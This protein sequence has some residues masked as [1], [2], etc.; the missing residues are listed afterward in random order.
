MPLQ[1]LGQFGVEFSPEFNF[2]QVTEPGDPVS[3]DLRFLANA[4]AF[5]AQFDGGFRR[6]G[7]T[8]PMFTAGGFGGDFGEE[9]EGVTLTPYGTVRAVRPNH[10]L[11]GR[12]VFPVTPQGLL[13]FRNP[14]RVKL[15]SS[16]FDPEAAGADEEVLGGQYYVCAYGC[17]QCDLLESVGFQIVPARNLNA[18]P[19]ILDEQGEML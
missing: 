13:L 7:Q 10:R 17:W 3:V 2:G 11:W 14:A 16:F 18:P 1:V 19:Y 12:V 5:S 8:D 9:F 15:V 6:A 4:R